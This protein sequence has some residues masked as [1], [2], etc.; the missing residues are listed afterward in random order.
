MQLGYDDDDEEML[1]RATPLEVVERDGE[2][3]AREGDEPLFS[4]LFTRQQA[5][6]LCSS[7]NS[8]MLMGRPRCPFCNRP[9]S[10]G[11][12]CEKQN[13]YHPVALN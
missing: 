10:E 6:Q 9:M 8:L 13:G 11:H 1:L 7:I 3:Y 4:V 2:F 12:I 5:Q